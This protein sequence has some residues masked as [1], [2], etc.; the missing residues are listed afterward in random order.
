MGAATWW[1]W[2]WTT[3]RAISAS[4][5]PARCQAIPSGPTAPAWCKRSTTCAPA[6]AMPACRACCWRAPCWIARRWTK[7][8]PCYATRRVPAAF[9]IRWAA[10]RTGA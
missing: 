2:P 8:P 9:T 6:S 4:I 1:T 3:R 10:H 7:G 5:T